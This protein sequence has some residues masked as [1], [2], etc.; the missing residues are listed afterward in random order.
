M[1]KLWLELGKF[2]KMSGDGKHSV[3]KHEDGHEIKIAHH[4]LSPKMRGQ[5]AEMREHKAE[6]G[7]VSKKSDLV[8]KDKDIVE[9]G[10]STKKDSPKQIKSEAADQSLSESSLIPGTQHT[11][12]LN[13]Y[14]SGGKVERD[15]EEQRQ[16]EA[17]PQY[18]QTGDSMGAGGADLKE[19]SY[20]EKKPNP[21]Y[22]MFADGGD[23]APEPV[24]APTVGGAQ[25][26]TIN[27][28][29][30]QAGVATTAAPAGGLLPMPLPNAP[31]VIGQQPE[32]MAKA[33]AAAPQAAVPQ[34]AAVAA[35]SP[36]PVAPVA[37][38]AG[39]APTAPQSAPND[40]YSAMSAGMGATIGGVKLGLE[41][42]DQQAAATAAMGNQQAGAYA[43][44]VK[45]LQS[46]QSHYQ[47]EYD[48]ATKES[49]QAIKDIQDQ[50]IDY[51]RY[52]GNMSTGSR[53]ATGIGVLL[54]GAAQGLNGGSNAALDFLKDNISRDVETQKAQLGQKQTLYSAY[55]NKFKNSHDATAMTQAIMGMQTIAQ[56]NQAASKAQGPLAI[57]AMNQAKGKIYTDVV[58][59]ATQKLAMNQ[60]ML[61]AN[62]S[63][64]TDQF[65]QVMRIMNPE[66]YKLLEPLHVPGIGMAT[67]PVPESA[68]KELI[69]KQTLNDSATRLYDWASK[70]SGSVS[71]TDINVGKTM[72]AELQSMYRDAING[73]VF[74]EGE[75]RFID[76][77]ISSDPTKF[78]NN[79]RVLPALKQVISSNNNQLGV[80]KK[81]YGLPGPT[82][83]QQTPYSSSQPGKK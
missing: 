17:K 83:I 21:E 56:I 70:H 20:T 69:A 52:L 50:H 15:A 1:A 80:L 11:A 32:D 77:I 25:P 14:E 67:H 55:L 64:N 53:I 22:R 39:L 10:S 49:N 42:L 79:I 41:G 40:P 68:R 78:F 74:K 71:P 48:N 4:A 33:E 65:M 36:E 31:G 47:Q 28:G 19:K 45:A 62:K 57:A 60:V 35:P 13:F 26:I 51:N 72:A 23:V 37:P 76:R 34:P 63:G 58:A 29:Q 5:L 54:G 2:K 18:D 8:E 46:M 24:P 61:G 44:Q 43:Q 12:S 75:Q 73:G 6:G 30:P 16:R 38:E 9:G 3:L 27:V 81:A 59:P 7:R 66:Q 82:Q